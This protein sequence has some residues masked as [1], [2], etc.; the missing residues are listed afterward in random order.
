[1]TDLLQREQQQCQQFEQKCQQLGVQL[2]QQQL[3]SLISNSNEVR[4]VLTNPLDLAG[5]GTLPVLTLTNPSMLPQCEMVT[6]LPPGKD[7]TQKLKKSLG[8]TVRSSR[9]QELVD[10]NKIRPQGS[11]HDSHMQWIS[12]VPV[13]QQ[14]LLKRTPNRQEIPPYAVKM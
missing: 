1:M 9:L 12:H 8:E 13:C 14:N 10:I 6:E 11:C 2:M 4:P 5:L 3:P 7:H